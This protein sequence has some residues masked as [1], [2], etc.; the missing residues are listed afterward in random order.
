MAALEGLPEGEPL[1]PAPKQAAGGS[2]DRQGSD[3]PAAADAE[4]DGWDDDV[5]GDWGL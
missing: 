5:Q 2:N 3:P 1:S 4:L